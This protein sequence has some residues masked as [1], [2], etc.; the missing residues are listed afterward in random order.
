MAT[1]GDDRILTVPNAI[2]TVRLLCIPVFVWLM[3][4][5]H[6]ESWYPAA[7]LL[8]A[9]GVT[10]GVDGYVARHF[11]QVSTVGKVL[12]PVA[13]RML[14]GVAG[15]TTVV[16]GAVPAWVGVTSLA[17]E[18]LVATG[19]LLVAVRGGVRMD[20]QWAGKAGTFAL[21]CALPLFLAG[22]ANDD[23]NNVAEVVAWVFVVPGLVLGWYAAVTYVPR[24][25]RAVDTARGEA[26]GHAPNP[27]A[28]EANI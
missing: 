10:D 2:T 19:F 20:V 12:D 22:H 6:R 27:T 11:G 28:E 21:M 9:L 3:L 25:R 7:L 8:G 1:V 4:R 5:P 26:Y 13:D 18:G 14:L 17:R 15:I 23:W 24:A 16:M